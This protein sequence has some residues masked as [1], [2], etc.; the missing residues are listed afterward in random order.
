MRTERLIPAL[1]AGIVGLVVMGLL[2]GC[3]SANVDVD[4]KGWQDVG[5]SYANTY[6]GSSDKDR[7]IRVARE[8][9]IEAGI[10]KDQ[11]SEYQYSATREDKVWWVRFR[12]PTLRNDSWP[13]W[14]MVRV[15]PDNKTLIYRDRATAPDR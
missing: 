14:F 3:F 15:D 11:L 6:G 13:G 12:H 2:G 9:A 10:K 5:R 4:S 8:A 7:A 1:V